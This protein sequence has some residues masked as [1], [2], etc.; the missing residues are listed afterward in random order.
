MFAV[1]PVKYAIAPAVVQGLELEVLIT[2]LFAD[3]EQLI[4][5]D[6]GLVEPTVARRVHVQPPGGLKELRAGIGFLREPIGLGK[7]RFRLDRLRAFLEDERAAKLQLRIELQARAQRRIRDLL[8]F[9]E[10]E[11]ESRRSNSTNARRS[12]GPVGDK[13]PEMKRLL[14]LP[15]RGC[16]DAR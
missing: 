3:R 12:T 6:L 9:R 4:A 2:E 13:Q 15:R 8:R 1:W 14:E 11:L 5:P 7:R 10:R 16:S